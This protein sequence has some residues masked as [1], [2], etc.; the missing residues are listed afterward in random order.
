MAN[1]HILIA[2]STLSAPSATID[3]QNISTAYSALRL[4]ACLRSN[5]AST[6]EVVKIA[7][8][9][10]TSQFYDMSMGSN[11]SIFV[12][13]DGGTASSGFNSNIMTADNSPANNFAFLEFND[14]FNKTGNWDNGHTFYWASVAPYDVSATQ[15]RHSTGIHFATQQ[16]TRLT[17]SGSS[18]GSFVAGSTVWLY[19]ILNT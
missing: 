14:P 1:T 5:L 15:V 12:T 10:S 2:K 9:S 11:G 16:T 3:I 19:G 18:G 4:I 6:T 7:R 8:N 13:S 17:L